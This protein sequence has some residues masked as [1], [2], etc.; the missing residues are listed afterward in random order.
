MTKTSKAP[1]FE[2]VAVDSN[3]EE[4]LLATGTFKSLQ[5]VMH[6]HLDDADEE[7]QY[8]GIEAYTPMRIQPYQGE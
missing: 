5:A 3:G 6:G 8:N 4:E 7:Y 1:A 2:L